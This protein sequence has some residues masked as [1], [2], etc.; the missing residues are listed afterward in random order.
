[1]GHRSN[2]TGYRIHCS[3]VPHYYRFVLQ[4]HVFVG[5]LPF[6]HFRSVGKIEGHDKYFEQ[7]FRLFWIHNVRKQHLQIRRGVQP[8]S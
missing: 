7:K 6:A 2:K 5:F 4:K 3:R 1:M 8:L